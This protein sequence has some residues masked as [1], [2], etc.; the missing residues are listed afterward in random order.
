[1][2]GS[3]LINQVSMHAST[4]L[5]NRGRSF[6]SVTLFRAW[7]YDTQFSMIKFSCSENTGD[8]PETYLLRSAMLL[9]LQAYI[10]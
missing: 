8:F 2:N 4:Y 3:F 5:I 1:M 10:P 9:K 7:F 6:F